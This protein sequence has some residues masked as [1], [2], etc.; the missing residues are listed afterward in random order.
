MMWETPLSIEQLETVLNSAPVAIYVSALENWELLY[1]NQLARAFLLIKPGKDGITCYQAAGFDAPCPF[2][3][4]GEMNREKLC[5][6]EFHHPG[7][8]RIYQLSGKLIDWA[9]R[10]AH[11]EYI[12]DITEKSRR[13]RGPEN[14]RKNCRPPSAVFRVACAYTAPTAVEFHP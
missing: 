5:V 1:A 6:R 2:C 4:T 11:I 7:N 13:R 3:H 10:S 9:G 8:G 14:V 12:V